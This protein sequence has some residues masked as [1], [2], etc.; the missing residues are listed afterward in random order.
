MVTSAHSDLVA[1]SRADL[2]ARLGIAPEL[3]ETVSVEDVDWRDSSLGVPQAGMMYA[4]VMTP[5]YRI[6][7]RANNRQYVYHADN[8]RV[9]FAGEA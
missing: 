4:Q 2:A 9:L 7:L 1:Q 6:V 8:R 5:G 3:T